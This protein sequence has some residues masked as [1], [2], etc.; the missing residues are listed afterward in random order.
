[1][2]LYEHVI[3]VDDICLEMLLIDITNYMK[4]LIADAEEPV[5]LNKIP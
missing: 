2:M 3:Y 1:M 5:T 4:V